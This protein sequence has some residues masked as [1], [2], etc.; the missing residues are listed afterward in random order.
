MQR[1]ETVR[2][3]TE[4][5]KMDIQTT[6]LQTVPP[7][8]FA[9]A[10]NILARKTPFMADIRAVYAKYSFGWTTNC[11]LVEWR[12]FYLENFN[13][14]V[15]FA[16]LTIPERRAGFTRLLVIAQGVT[17]EQVFQ[18]C[19]QLFGAW[20]YTNASLDEAVITNDRDP[21][22]GSYAIWVRDCVEADEGWKNK[23]ANDLANIKMTGETL[24]ERL[25]HELKYF[26]ET[27]KHLD[28]ENWTLCSGS[29]N[30]DGR[31]LRVHWYGPNSGL[32]V[33]WCSVSVAYGY[34]R[35]RQVVAAAPAAA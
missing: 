20:K 5:Q 8:S 23:S 35:S 31:V 9:D 24:L 4:G 17:I 33:H 1:H 30:S 18:K 3:M 32:G 7:L 13:L 12:K 26:R 22:N 28:M 10:E 34:L 29:H 14:K 27:G 15:N 21:K 11:T 2:P 16:S 6:L 25:I 19:K